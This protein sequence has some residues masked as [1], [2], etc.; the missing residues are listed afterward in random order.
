MDAH[1]E[2]ST[3]SHVRLP[4]AVAAMEGTSDEPLAP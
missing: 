3:L 2:L 4:G 1:H